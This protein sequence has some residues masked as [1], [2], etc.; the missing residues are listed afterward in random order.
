[1]TKT[2]T[3]SKILGTSIVAFAVLALM[4]PANMAHATLV[5]DDVTITLLGADPG[6]NPQSPGVTATVQ[7]GAPEP[8]FVWD[9]ALCAFDDGAA[10]DI[11]DSTITVSWGGFLGA[12]VI[13]NSNGDILDQPLDF[14]ITSLDWVNNPNGIVADISET[15]NSGVFPT[16][17]QVLGDHS[18]RVTVGVL[19]SQSGEVVFTLEKKVAVDIDIKPGSDPNS[20]NVN[21]KKGVTPVAILGSA[22]FDVTTIDAT[23]LTFGPSGASTAHDLSD[24]LVLADHQQD[25]NLDGFTDLVAHFSTPDTGI[26]PG[27]TDACINGLLLDATPLMGCDSV[28]TIPPS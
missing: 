18:V 21:K 19:N 17:A 22:T 1:M 3:I 16:T 8:E 15:S 2:K 11:E 10:V 20:I 25:V 27:D 23:T 13:C 26:A 6:N 9:D 7:G 28:R 24:A 12:S 4:V 5:G 14:T